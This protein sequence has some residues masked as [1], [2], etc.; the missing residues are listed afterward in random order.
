MT[1]GSGS[2]S[3]I[4]RKLNKAMNPIKRKSLEAFEKRK[5]RLGKVDRRKRVKVKILPLNQKSLSMYIEKDLKDDEEPIDVKGP[6]KEES[7]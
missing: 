4:R 1:E 3:E 7:S 6:K 2:L 5:K